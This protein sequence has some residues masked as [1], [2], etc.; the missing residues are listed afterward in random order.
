M[1]ELNF[2][3]RFYEKDWRALSVEFNFQL[4]Q[5]AFCDRAGLEWCRRLT[6]DYKEDVHIAHSLRFFGSQAS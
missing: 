5:L 6:L 3:T 4:H 1:P 2:L